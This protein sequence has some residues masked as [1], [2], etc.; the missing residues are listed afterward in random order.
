MLGS[1][2]LIILV[3]NLWGRVRKLESLL[4]SGSFR[5]QSQTQPEFHAST[6]FKPQTELPPLPPVYRGDGWFGS[7]AGLSIPDGPDWFE[8]FAAWIKEDWLLKL[9]ALLL[10]IGFGWLASYAFIN[11]WIGPVGRITLGM[12]AGIAVL[13]FGWVRVQKYPAQGSIFVVLGSTVFLLTTFA[14]RE[15]YDFLTPSTALAM[16]FATT[17]LVAFMSVRYKIF[18]L[19]LCSLVLASIAPLLINSPS[20]DYVS[21]FSYLLVII[22]GAVWVTVL[23]GGRGLTTAALLV[24]I[25]YSLP[26][27]FMLSDADTGMLL[28]FAYAFAAIFFITNILGITKA[29]NKSLISDLMTAAGNGLLLL[30]WIMIAA[31]EEWKS[32]IIAAWTVVF[33]CGAYVVFKSVERKEPFYIYA[34]LGVAMIA[35]ATSVELQGAS[36]TIAYTIES[37]IVG[38]TA[39]YVLKD[40]KVAK[41]LSWLFI[42]P[43]VSS[44]NSIFSDSWSI[45]VFNEDFFVLLVLGLSILSLG[46]FLWKISREKNLPSSFAKS[47]MILGSIYFY[48]LIWLSLQSA[49]LDDNTAI[50][51]AL[52]TYTIVGLCAYFYGLSRSRTLYIYGGVILGFVVLR[53]LFIDAWNMELT[54]RII[55]FFS[56]GALLVSTAFFGRKK[57]IKADDPE[58]NNKILK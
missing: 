57:L 40:F 18:S 36:L 45:S 31:P 55:T 23:I 44:L 50:M 12:I 17:V 52:I 47:L 6:Q 37:L 19:A 54:G 43:S 2:V 13:L 30:A 8:R 51:I 4:S 29:A 14:A 20:A 39:Y 21:L 24:V 56:V 5:P 11:N 10:L 25:F 41:A 33:V 38:L 1:V 34:G 27:L 22:L 48:I 35:A 15:I 32:L 7:D 16:M 3:F 26:H 9:G 53:L 49:L 28:L 42:I 58:I 46:Y